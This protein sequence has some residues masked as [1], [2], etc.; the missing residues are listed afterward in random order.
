MDVGPDASAAADLN[1]D[2]RPD[3]AVT[4]QNC[5]NTCASTSVSVL[6]NRGNGTFYTAVPYKTD[7]DPVSIAAGDFDGDGTVD[8]AVANAIATV[9]RGPGEVSIYLNNG[10]GV[11]RLGG[12]YFA[13]SRCGS[14]HDRETRGKQ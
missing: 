5:N 6:L 10:A 9:Q 14:A 11:F 4:N 12:K 7:T 1:G 2:G 3:L 13:V 8:L